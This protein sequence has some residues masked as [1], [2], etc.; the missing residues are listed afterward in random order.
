MHMLFFQSILFS[1]VAHK[2]KPSNLEILRI[3]PLLRMQGDWEDQGTLRAEDTTTEMHSYTTCTSKELN[4]VVCNVQF[5][6]GLGRLAV[7]RW[8]PQLQ[9]VEFHSLSAN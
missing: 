5:G 4:V 9:Q 7:Y 2:S 6:E 3:S 1:C 8:D